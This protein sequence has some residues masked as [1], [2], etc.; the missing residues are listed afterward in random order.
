MIWKSA[1][2][3]LIRELAIKQLYGIPDERIVLEVSTFVTACQSSRTPLGRTFLRNHTVAPSETEITPFTVHNA[4]IIQEFLRN[5]ASCL[6]PTRP[7]ANCDQYSTEAGPP[8][9]P[10]PNTDVA[11]TSASSSS[12]SKSSSLDDELNYLADIFGVDPASRQPQDYRSGTPGLLDN[13]KPYAWE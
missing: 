6:P 10:A 13:L 1:A 11:A 12:Q 7:G 5:P 9:D 2:R 4:Q 3:A 8:S